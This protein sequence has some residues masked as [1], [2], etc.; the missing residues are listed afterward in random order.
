MNAPLPGFFRVRQH[1]ADNSLG[2]VAAAVTAE[3]ERSSL[4]RRIRPG[5]SVAIAVGSRGIDQVPVIVRAVV[6][7]VRDL[8]G[9]P[10]IVPAMGSHGG[11]TAEGQAAVLAEYGIAPAS[12]GCEVR[13]SMEVCELG[14]TSSDVPV[15]FD[16]LA[17]AA[18]HV[19]VVNRVKPH[20][21]IS[22]PYESGLLKMML[23]GLGKHRGAAAYHQAMAQQRFEELVH[24]VVPLIL[25]RVPISLGI[26]IVENAHDR[27]AQ[28]AAIEPE[29]L[30]EREPELLQAARQMMPRLPF[31]TADLLIVD[32]IGKNISG[33]GLDTNVVGRKFHDKLAGEHEWPKIS[34]IYVRGLTPQSAGNAAGI[35]IAEYCR[36][37]LVRQMDVE[38]T[39][40]NCLTALHI[41]SAAI[42][43]HW[44]TDREVL[45]AAATQAGR[46]SPRDLR[47]MWIRDTLHVAE[48]M[49]S[50]AYLSEADGR[51]DLSIIAPAA[52]LRLDAS[53]QLLDLFEQ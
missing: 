14:R 34:Q 5:D 37:D 22:G 21:Q 6:A 49:C 24:Q 10:W 45:L 4:A 29:R 44:E 48:L 9:D 42:P 47:W 32:Q 3:I 15:Y 30:L 38:K 53:G 33:S 35:G 12:V 17:A 11:A 16:A 27:V 46:S 7:A 41:T 39:R 25:Q 26:A 18:D 31:D 1:F 40:I 23:I 28:V 36:S 43:I 52:P 2:D 13:A 19:I 50:E 8:G 51:E 20:T